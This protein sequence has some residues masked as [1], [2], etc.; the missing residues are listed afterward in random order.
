MTRRLSSIREHHRLSL[1]APALTKCACLS[2][3]QQ[4]AAIASVSA[5]LSP[6]S[7]MLAA[8]SG[9]WHPFSRTPD[10]AAAPNGCALSP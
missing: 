4:K 1:A 9:T 10:V 5:A 2:L 7:G 8:A 6:S 3:A